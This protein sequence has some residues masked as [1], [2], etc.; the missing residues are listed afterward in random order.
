VG[1]AAGRP[2]FVVTPSRAALAPGEE[3]EIKVEFTSNTLQSYA[4]YCVHMSMEGIVDDLLSLP[5]FGTC[6]VPSV[7]MGS[8]IVEFGDCFV[9]YPYTKTVTLFNADTV[10]ARYTIMPQDDH[11]TV[12]ALI[13]RDIVSGVVPAQ[14]SVEVPLTLT[15]YKVGPIALPVYISIAGASDQAL[16]VE[17]QAVGTGPIVHLQPASLSWGSIACLKPVT[18]TLTILNDSLIPAPMQLSTR[19]PRSRFA[20]SAAELLLSAGE[21]REVHIT[22]NLDD[23]AGF[24][25]ELLVAVTESPTL[26]VPLQ[27]RGAGNTIHTEHDLSAFDF[28]Q[29][30]TNTPASTTFV[31]ENRGRRNQTVAWVNATFKQ[32]EAAAKKEERKRT[33]ASDKPGAGASA[34]ATGVNVT[35]QA[36]AVL[37]AAAAPA[38]PAAVGDAALPAPPLFS[39]EPATMLLKPGCS[40]SFTLKCF[41]EKPCDV[42]EVMEVQVRGEND[43]TGVAMASM[44]VHALLVHPLIEFQ[45]SELRFAHNHKSEYDVPLPGTMDLPS[46]TQTQQL[47]LRNTSKLP[48]DF[49]LRSSPPFSL[50]AYEFNVPAGESVC[51]G[52]TFDPTY[53]EDK[54]S[55]TVDARIT[56]VYRDHPRRDTVKVTGEINFA[57]LQLDKSSIDFGCVLNDTV[58]SRFVHVSN[59]S[60]LPVH[61]AWVFVEEEE[62][63]RSVATAA[64]VEY[65][66]INR[67]F[68]IRPIRCTLAPGQSTPVEFIFYG[69]PGRKF[70]CSAVC[71][72][73]GGPDYEVKLL[74]E[75]NTAAFRVDKQALD[76]GAVPFDT[77]E[78]RDFFIQNTGK[79]GYA[80]N[81]VVPES[82]IPGRVVVTPPS[83]T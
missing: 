51:V 15:V 73:A 7:S 11:S 81:V 67:A 42:T 6:V 39:V 47:T 45:P 21:R 75:A 29:V 57:N 38:V 44:S 14:G 5:I 26:S 71:E 66:P 63:A 3:R 70:A 78:T 61:L 83:G 2:E 49:T 40:H 77:A 56:A 23:V 35:P 30:F 41:S 24:A 59:V 37:T 22:A 28:G 64:G 27:A 17:V 10:P 68:D 1:A 48:L 12:I 8:D 65:I 72:V 16:K 55:H 31:L 82:E 32:R 54:M 52:V 74:G 53:R 9:R 20:C 18:H 76:F 60:R 46:L 13:H 62:E 69:H 34:A 19:N 36:S 58:T 50:D 33:G 43:R 79:V 80:F 4:G 25:D